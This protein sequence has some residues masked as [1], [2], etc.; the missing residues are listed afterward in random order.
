MFDINNF[1]GNKNKI[2]DSGNDGRWRR[3]KLCMLAIVIMNEPEGQNKILGKTESIYV[4]QTIL[5]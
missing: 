2:I 1:S 3:W 5:C 4:M